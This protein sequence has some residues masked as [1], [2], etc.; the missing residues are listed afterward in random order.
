ME[1]RILGCSGGEAEGERLTGLLVNDR[2]AIDAGSLTLALGVAEQV[3]IRHIFLTHSHLDHICTL[4][5]FTKNIFG[6]VEVPVEIHALP[7][8][9][10]ALRRHLFNDELWPDFSVIPSPD[11][12][13]I[14]YSEITPGETYHVEGLRITPVMVNHLVP[15]VGYRVEGDAAAFIFTSD[16]AETDEIYALANETPNLKFFITE[17]SFPNELGWLA[18]ASKHL[19]PAKLGKELRKLKKP[20]PVGIYHLTPGDRGIMLPQ[21]EALKHPKLRLLTQDERYVW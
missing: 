11:K 19:T 3:A 21:L 5:F 6:H 4:P 7:E 14:R 18:E 20:V 15:C 13:V 17:A 9:L 2:V 16:T 10:D 12:P 8:T 1:L